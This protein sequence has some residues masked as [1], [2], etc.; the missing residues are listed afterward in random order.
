MKG[1]MNDESSNL[2]SHFSMFTVSSKTIKGMH[3]C[4]YIYFEREVY[5]HSTLILRGFYLNHCYSYSPPNFWLKPK[6][7]EKAYNGIET[8][9]S[10]AYAVKC[11]ETKL[12]FSSLFPFH[13][14]TI[15]RIFINAQFFSNMLC[16]TN[17]FY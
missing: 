1:D 6:D 12:F 3:R 11:I 2:S 5:F 4:L 17:V 8:V 9:L 14:N 15:L 7:K 13:T 10:D 16:S